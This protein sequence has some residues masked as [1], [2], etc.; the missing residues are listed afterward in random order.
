MSIYKV[1]FR[2]T[3]CKCLWVEDAPENPSEDKTC[4]DCS[5]PS[6]KLSLYNDNIANIDDD[7][8]F[9]KEE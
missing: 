4:P 8:K 7:F 9:D 5:C 3:N 1:K 6:L 2:C